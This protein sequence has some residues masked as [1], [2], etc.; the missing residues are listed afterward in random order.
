[1]LEGGVIFPIEITYEPN[2]QGIP[3]GRSYAIYRHEQFFDLDFK[4]GER[5]YLDLTIA[6]DTNEG[7]DRNT[8]SIE[9]Y[10]YLD[11]GIGIDTI[12]DI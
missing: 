7:V 1:V 12:A 9:F 4:S 8:F 5:L 3:P 6:I 2:P 11:K 10:P